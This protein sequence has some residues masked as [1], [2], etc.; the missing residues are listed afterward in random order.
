MENLIPKPAS[1][2]SSLL[3]VL[4][5][6]SIVALMGTVLVYV[7]LSIS[8]NNTLAILDRLNLSLAEMKTNEQQQLQDKALNY[9][10]KIKDFNSLFTA[11]QSVRDF[12]KLLE[13]NTHPQVWFSDIRLDI[14]EGD[15]HLSAAAKD[16]QSVEQQFIIFK[17]LKDFSEVSLSDISIGKQGEISFSLEIALNP[18]L[19]EFK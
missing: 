13:E 12:F 4:F 18:E 16:F 8:V 17:N 2:P 1:K 9:Q 10:K 5:Y 3:N 15:L 11:H 7:W 6:V 19:F 14:N